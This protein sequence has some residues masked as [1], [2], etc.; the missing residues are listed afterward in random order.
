M[1]GEVVH[2]ELPVENHERAGKFYHEVFGWKSM[3]DPKLNYTMVETTE[4]NEQRMPKNPGS[5]NGGFSPRGGAV[6][7]PVVTILVDEIA[8]AEKSIQKHGGKVVQKKTAIGDGAM[9][10]VAYFT[11]PEGNLVGLYQRGSM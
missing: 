3:H 6:K 11:D 10:H 1:S 7:A 8:D 5:I 9:G 4:V 2:F